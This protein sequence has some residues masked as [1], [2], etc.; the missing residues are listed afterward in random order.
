VG[1]GD[2]RLATAASR[3]LDARDVAYT[4]HAALEIGLRLVDVSEEADAERLCADA[5]RALRLRDAAVLATR[6]PLVAPLPGRPDRDTLPERLPARYVQERIEASL[7]ATKLDALPLVQL[8][9]HAG[10]RASTAWPELVGACARFVHEGKV[11]AYAAALDAATTAAE[12]ESEAWIAA[13]AIEF[14][15]CART[16]APLLE[17]KRPIL[18]RHPLAGGALAGTLGPGVALK[19]RD[20]RNAIDVPTLERMA[21]LAATLAPLVEHEPAAARSC[22]PAK[23]ALDRGRRPDHVEAKT[24]AELALRY[25]CDRAI[26]LPRLHRRDRQH[27]LDAVSAVI[28]P[29]LS[30][31]ARERIDEAA[32]KLAPNEA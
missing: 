5:I 9:I 2:V 15:I 10:W 22:E 17:G 26:A 11:L 4:V 23:A 8:P 25:V 6:V 1:C 20:D 19:P 14:S 32:T 27:L 12:L 16:A 21:T 24:L 31:A 29:P 7:R 13:F 3:G 28:A 30:P 18:A